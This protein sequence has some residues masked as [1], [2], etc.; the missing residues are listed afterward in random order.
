MSGPIYSTLV[1]D[2]DYS[3]LVSEFVSKVPERVQSIRQSIEGNDSKQLCTLIHQLKGACGSYGFHEITPLAA[4]IEGEIRKGRDIA[5]LVD[6]LESF[7]GTCLRMTSEP[8]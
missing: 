3:E 8:A 7:I 1:S 5:S 6:S 2:P 4:S